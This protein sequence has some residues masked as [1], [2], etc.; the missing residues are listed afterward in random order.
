MS[1]RKDSLVTRNIQ[2]LKREER[3]E[4]RQTIRIVITKLTAT[5]KDSLTPTKC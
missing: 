3:K 2:Q 1:R 4:I 5:A